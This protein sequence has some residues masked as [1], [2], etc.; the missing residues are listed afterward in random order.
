MLEFSGPELFRQRLVLACVSGKPIRIINIRSNEE[1]PGL[2]GIFHLFSHSVYIFLDYEIL[3]LRFLET[4]TNGSV[5]EINYTG[6]AVTFKPGSILGGSLSFD[7][8]S[9]RAIGYFLEPIL[10]VAPFSKFAFKLCLTGMTSHEEDT[11]IDI[12][13]TVFIKIL[14]MFGVNEGLDLKISK[15]GSPPL[16]GGEVNFSCPVVSNLQ[17]VDLSDSGR[18]KRIRGIAA[19]TRISPQASNRLVESCRSV[20]NTFIPDI[21]IYSDVFK[22]PEA[23]QS[24]GFGVSL[25]A[26]TTTGGLLHADMIGKAGM[27]PEE[28][29]RKTSKKLLAEIAGAGYISAKANYFVL[30][31]M[32]L[33]I[34]NVNKICLRSVKEEDKAIMSVIKNMLGVSFKSVQNESSGNYLVS[35]VGSGYVNFNQRMQ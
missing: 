28:V 29:G 22:G 6:T 33:T 21:Y 18:V 16:G 32:A 13:R 5:I 23:G 7:C 27:T 3:F 2:K 4:L 24:P 1:N 10:L 8:G 9:E 14:A 17:N 20:L 30:A 26:E 35:C 15:R 34:D 12:I 19:V 31:L 25:V 11:S